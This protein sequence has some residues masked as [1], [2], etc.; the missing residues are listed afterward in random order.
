MVMMNCKF[1]DCGHT[2]EYKGNSP[3]YITCPQCLRKI[4]RKRSEVPESVTKIY[5][6]AERSF[7]ERMKLHKPKL[8]EE[9]RGI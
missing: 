2:W 8:A 9:E 5:L 4:K 1:T 3:I 6:N 7:H